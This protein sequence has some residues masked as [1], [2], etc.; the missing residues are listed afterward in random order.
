MKGSKQLDGRITTVYFILT[1]LEF[2]PKI[3]DHMITNAQ[4]NIQASKILVYK[5]SLAI[6]SW[7]H[8]M[9][10]CLNYFSIILQVVASESIK[11]IKNVVKMTGLS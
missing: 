11:F 4:V 10:G 1:K 7:L 6:R 9:P 2:I 8:Q 5:N 3:S